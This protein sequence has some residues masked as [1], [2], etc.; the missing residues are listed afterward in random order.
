MI[1]SGEGT[2]PYVL[3]V[4]SHSVVSDSLGPLGYSP[5]G[6]SVHGISPGKN[7][8]VGSHSFFQGIFPTQG[9]NLGLLHDR[10]ILYCLRHQCGI[11]GEKK[12]M[13]VDEEGI[14]RQYHVDARGPGQRSISRELC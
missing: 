13:R 2:Q 4:L 5:P 7:T 1:V 12:E 9:S 8:G 6:S 14:I 3:C 10:Q 11:G